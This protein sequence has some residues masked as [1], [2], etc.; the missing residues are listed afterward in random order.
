MPLLAPT[1]ALNASAFGLPIGTLFHARPMTQFKIAGS[2]TRRS[3]RA[4]VGAAG[5]LFAGCFLILDIWITSPLPTPPGAPFRAWP[6]IVVTGAL[7]L[8]CGS[9]TQ[10]NGGMV[11]P[12]RRSNAK[13]VVTP[14]QDSDLYV[15]LQ[16]TRSDSDR[17]ALLIET[18]KHA[19]LFDQLRA[20]IFLK[21]MGPRAAPAVPMLLAAL[22]DSH[23]RIRGAAAMVLG[24]IGS[25][26]IPAA[27]ALM[28][29]LND[30][31]WMVA[32]NAQTALRQLGQP[33]ITPEAITVLEAMAPYDR[34]LA[35]DRLGPLA[36]AITVDLPPVVAA[37]CE[38][39]KGEPLEKFGPYTP[40][41]LIEVVS[42]NCDPKIG[43]KA[44]AA[45]G[46]MGPQALTAVP[47]LIQRSRRDLRVFGDIS[48][49]RDAMLALA[50]VDVVA[51][52]P[53]L[54]RIS[55]QVPELWWD[56]L[57]TLAAAG[58]GAAP[59]IPELD[60]R[61]LKAPNAERKALLAVTMWRIGERRTDVVDAITA[62]LEANKAHFFSRLMLARALQSC[63][64]SEF[65]PSLVRCLDD[66]C[67]DMV[68]LAAD[69]LATFGEIA[70]AAIPQLTEIA[71]G[72]TRHARLVAAIALH[73]IDPMSEIP[74]SAMSEM[75]A[76]SN[77]F[78]ESGDDE[79]AFRIW[80]GST[81]PR[82]R[83]R[84][85]HALAEMGHAARAAIPALR[86]AA[87]VDD[88]ELRCAAL[89]ALERIESA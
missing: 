63:G 20:A 89:A 67:H 66:E 65:I 52:I 16:N 7:G 26:A 68:A 73:K 10:D 64:A 1:S 88:Q 59:A 2:L 36:A 15:R 79:G 38:G 82:D 69:V 14:T 42:Q 28:R 58:P 49:I 48:V 70:S 51:A 39:K 9:L 35:V 33:A 21:E 55:D 44:I 4:L 71:M 40:Q 3:H 11:V 62:I 12:A 81:T 50:K 22:S 56:A 32:D 74:V 47:F 83:A 72:P 17:L 25:A 54:L 87:E 77:K 8:I 19:I 30:P 34:K 75:V 23:E 86:E 61:L 45:L 13:P 6:I 5:G 31:G 78:A 84:V 76:K 29:C 85:A 53:E 41:E 46:V 43:S 80:I 27:P 37:L 24:S 60:N 57:K 18:F